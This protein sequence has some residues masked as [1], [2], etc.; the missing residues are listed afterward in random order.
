M[1]RMSVE[2]RKR[3]IVLRSRGYSVGD[4]FRR[5]KEEKIPITRQSLYN[6]IEKFRVQQTVSDMPR[7]RRQRII[8]DEMRQFIQDALKKDDELTATKIR[9]LLLTSWPDLYL[10]EVPS[11]ST[12][13]R[14]RKDMGWVCTRPYYCQII[15]QVSCFYQCAIR[16]LATIHGHHH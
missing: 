8:T 13:K 16:C 10:R 9:D 7:R 5:F 14:T 6:L 2:L 1:G 3:V 11:I 4:I 12:I 15:R